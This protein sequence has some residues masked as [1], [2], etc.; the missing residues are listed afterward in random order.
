MSLP[1]SAMLQALSSFFSFEVQRL[2]REEA[3]ERVED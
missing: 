3:E 1:F 2:C